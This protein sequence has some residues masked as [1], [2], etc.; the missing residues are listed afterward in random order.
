[1]GGKLKESVGGFIKNVARNPLENTLTLGGAALYKTAGQQTGAP[2]PTSSSFLPELKANIPG[3]DL[4]GGAKKVKGFDMPQTLEE[5]EMQ[6][7]QRQAGIA[8][9]DAQSISGLQFQKNMD[10]INKAGLAMANSQR[11]SSN[12]AL[13]FRQAQIDAQNAQLQGAQ[14]SAIA[15]EQERRQADQMIG[16]QAASQRGVALQ[17]SMANQKADTDYR[18]QNMGIV[19]NLGAAGVKAASDERVKEHKKKTTDSALKAVD[20]FLKSVEPYQYEYKNSDDTVHNGIMAQDLEKSSIGKQMVVDTPNGKVVDYGQGF[21]AMMAS[22][23]EL[24]KKVSKMQK[25]KA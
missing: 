1:M 21:S 4:F 9:G 10:D 22:I 17:Q 8:S 25:K 15:E 14:S 12:P 20:E 24:D 19:G 6:M 23:A 16:A 2:L 7:I 5:A 13:A 11:G 3:A 18:A